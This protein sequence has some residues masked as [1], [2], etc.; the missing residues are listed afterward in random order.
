VTVRKRPNRCVDCGKPKTA[1]RE[2]SYKGLCRLCS[3]K[4]VEQNLTEMVT[5]EGPAY[6]TWRIRQATGSM[7]HARRV[8]EGTG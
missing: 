5:K 1:K 3:V 2:I 6:E 4:R 7:E 8:L